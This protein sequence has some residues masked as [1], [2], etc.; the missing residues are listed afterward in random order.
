VPL[1]DDDKKQIMINFERVSASHSAPDLDGMTKR[2]VESRRAGTSSSVGAKG[3]VGSSLSMLASQNAALADNMFNQVLPTPP[4][5]EREFIKGGAI[6]SE[7]SPDDHK[8]IEEGS[9]VSSLTGAGY[10]QEIV[11]ELHQALTELRGELE[12]SRA[13]AARAVKV[14]EQAIQSAENSSSRDWNSTV[15]HKAAEAA[16]L[17]QKKSAE[18]MAKAR[19]AEERLSGE[20]KTASFW[21]KQAEAAEEEAGMLQTRAAAAEVQRATMAEELVTERKR[22]SEI[23]SALQNRFSEIEEQQREA[24]ETVIQRT[25]ELE[26]ELDG[27][28]RDLCVK[29]QEAKTLKDDLTTTAADTR[30]SAVSKFSLMGKKKIVATEK[31][32]LLNSESS[33]SQDHDLNLALVDSNKKFSNEDVLKI[34][35]EFSAV[36]LQFELLKRSTTD[37]FDGIPAV[38]AFWT[39]QATKAISHSQSEILTLRERLALEAATRRRLLNEVQD[40]RGNIRVYC[41]P[42]PSNS[43]D[44][45]LEI[46]SNEVLLLQRGKISQDNVQPLSF[47]YDHVFGSNAGQKE[48]YSEV[49]ELVLSVLD[50]FNI[51]MIVYGPSECGKTY[52]MLGD[53]NY[54]SKDNNE[55][56]LGDFGLHLQGVQQLFTVSDRRS[57]RYQDSFSLS[58]VEVHD[59]KVHDVVAGTTVGDAKGVVDMDI[60]KLFDRKK[61]R[62]KRPQCEGDSVPGNSTTSRSGRSAK[63]EIRTNS[64]GET[65]VQGL[66]SV[67]VASLEEV[68]DVWKQALTARAMRLNELGIDSDTYEAS[69]HMIATLQVVSRNVATGVGSVGK[70]Q[71]VDLA[72]A[73]LIGSQSSSKKSRSSSVVDGVLAPVG[74][75]KEWRFAQKSISTLGEVF[76]ARSQFSRAVPYRNS[77]LTHLLSDSLEG[78]TKVMVMICV[79][80]DPHDAQETASTLRFGTKAKR[81]NIG[82]ATKHALH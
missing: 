10:D 14:A 23:V 17:A 29:S 58:I 82:K 61:P 51:C 55:I 67:Q 18:A 6:V 7:F 64:D 60:Q 72:G 49:E 20:R 22:S 62:R 70:I 54:P 27:T 53:I 33:S 73:D 48:V 16:A 24:Y 25:R 63:L 2:T 28:R 59:E 69:S 42:K 4:T 3:F 26:V 37:E 57:E 41:R 40:L 19:L 80:S 30:G 21:R 43:D 66:V 39:K 38:S 11:E 1:E 71:F 5:K 34:H 56:E 31:V 74:N 32:A 52:T 15:T 45:L 65:I 44:R 68:I 8:P 77:T 13:E 81:V 35:A 46:P 9:I 76:Q 12:T 47:E 50:G 78:D 79:S 75:N 36:K